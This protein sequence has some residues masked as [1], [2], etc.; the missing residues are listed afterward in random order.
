[1]A[2]VELDSD[3]RRYWEAMRSSVVW[4]DMGAV[5]ESCIYFP[6]DPGGEYCV[7]GGEYDTHPMDRV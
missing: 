6:I 3:V 2:A 4:F 1:M 5:G 7:L